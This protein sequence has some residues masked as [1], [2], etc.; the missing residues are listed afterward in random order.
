MS[1][2]AGSATSRSEGAAGLLLLAV[3]FGLLTGFGELGLLAAK[4][5]VMHRFISLSRDVLWMAPV[6]DVA[7]FAIPGLIL[8]A[9][10]AWRPGLVP[11]RIALFIYAFLGFLSGLLMYPP[12]HKAAALL[13]AG[14]LAVQTARLL[15]A[16]PRGL[17]AVVRRSMPWMV[18]LVAVLAL[19]V[20][21]WRRIWNLLVETF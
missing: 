18:T 2:S 16:R 12:L 21:G 5:F 13:L 8:A 15:A 4:K 9:I 10:A 14:G 6:A 1:G 17:H 7:L 19:G 11:L 20:H 3:W